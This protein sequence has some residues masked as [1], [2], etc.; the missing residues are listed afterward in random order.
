MLLIDY[1]E[2]STLEKGVKVSLLSD[3]FTMYH[4]SK[5]SGT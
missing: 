5:A 1:M 2:Q 4:K 3:K